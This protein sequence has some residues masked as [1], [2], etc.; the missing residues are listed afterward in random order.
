MKRFTLAV[1][2]LCFNAA[3]SSYA[4]EP[5]NDVLLPAE[6][7]RLVADARVLLDQWEGDGRL[8][9]KAEA[10]LRQVLG[11]NPNHVQAR[12]QMG[13]YEI[14]NGKDGN[15]FMSDSL[16][17]AE[18]ELQFAIGIDPGAA[19][20]YVLLAQVYMSL[21]NG[22][23]A[24]EA[25]K[26]AD[27]IG[28]DVPS[29]DVTWADF[30]IETKQ[31]DAAKARLSRIL[32][33]YA[34]D[35]NPPKAVHNAYGMLKTIYFREGNLEEVQK[36]YLKQITLKPNSAWNHGDYAGFLL[37]ELGDA[38]AAIDE[39]AKALAIVDYRNAKVTLAIAQYA[40]WT[41]LK[42]QQPEK[43]HEYYALAQQVDPSF[44]WTMSRAGSS[45][46]AGPA[47]EGLVV[48]LIQQG[49]SI[50]IPA[51]G[52]TALT[53][54]SGAGDFKT[55]AWLLEHGAN[56]NAGPNWAVLSRAKKA[57][58]TQVVKKLIE[59]GARER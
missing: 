28:S 48:M 47:I 10:N 26:K 4:G 55:V 57:G 50:D 12:I 16:M 58:H 36:I 34:N 2:W 32:A 35:K 5:T 45:V 31:W 42:A 22:D 37:L 29:L 52:D 21:G 7:E 41:Q 25:L 39:A 38:D 43:A 14:K 49:V 19:Y 23:K 6:Q 11:A 18:K 44:S 56:V 8:L 15:R 27:A 3:I 13:R 24:L 33:R 46:Y 9:H 59:Y 17:R 1:V 40:K 20:A 30:L 54:A 51:D 53:L